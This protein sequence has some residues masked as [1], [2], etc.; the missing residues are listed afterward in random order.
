[1]QNPV[2]ARVVTDASDVG[3]LVKRSALVS[4]SLQ[5][6]EKRIEEFG[7]SYHPHVKPHCSCGLIHRSEERVRRDDVMARTRMINQSR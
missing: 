7:D 1:M 5:I 4:D 2:V 3:A 6:A